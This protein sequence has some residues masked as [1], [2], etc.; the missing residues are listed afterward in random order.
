MP[1]HAVTPPRPSSPAP[2]HVRADAPR[3]AP[4]LSAAEA[5][6][7]SDLVGPG[8]PPVGFATEQVHGGEDPEEG[9]G[10][11]VTPVHLTAGFVF[12]SFAHARARFAGEDDGYTYTRIGNPTVAALERRLARLEGGAEAVVVGAARPR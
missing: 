1:E 3:P 9:F 12:D 4:A 8:L 6:A 11:R 10:A 2:G 5:D 7:F